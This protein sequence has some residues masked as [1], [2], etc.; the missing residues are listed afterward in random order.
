MFWRGPLDQFPSRVHAEI[1]PPANLGQ[2]D[3]LRLKS[4]LPPSCDNIETRPSK[5]THSTEYLETDKTTVLCANESSSYWIS[6]QTCKWGNEK[7]R[8][9]P[10]A[11]FPDRRDLRDQRWGECNEGARREAIDDGK[12]NCWN[13]A[14]GRKPQGKDNNGGNRGGHNHG[15]EPAHAISHNAREDSSKYPK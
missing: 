8:A 9:I 10:D 6:Y 15:I 13:I 11:D 12:D 2:L 7:A 14:L 4:G 5:H 3:D 1:S